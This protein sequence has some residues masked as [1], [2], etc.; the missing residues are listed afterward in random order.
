MKE[1]DYLEFLSVNRKNNFKMSLKW[2]WESM[3]RI[4]LAKNTKNWRAVVNTAMNLMI[5]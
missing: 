1:G 4:D 3:D 5:S 2:G